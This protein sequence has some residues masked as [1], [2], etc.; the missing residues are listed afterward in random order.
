MKA[1]EWAAW[2]YAADALW[3]VPG[4]VKVVQATGPREVAL[5]GRG[6]SLYGFD[7][8]KAEQEI[9]SVSAGGA[10]TL[11]EE[12][13]A[14]CPDREDPDDEPAQLSPERMEV[15]QGEL[16]ALRPAKGAQDAPD[17][18]VGGESGVSRNRYLGISCLA[19]NEPFVR[20]GPR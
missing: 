5:E 6:G 8:E 16:M 2:G 1:G 3:E 20:F 12:L 15:D 11:A 18:P 14:C 17:A 13:D 4:A 7:W 9:Q 19:C 10:S